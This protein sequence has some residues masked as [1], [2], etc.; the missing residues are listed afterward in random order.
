MYRCYLAAEEKEKA[1]YYKDLIL[2]QFP[3][4]EYARIITNPNYFKDAQRK[5][6]I[7]QVFYE[8]TYKAYVNG[9]Y[10]DVI[11]R[12]SA[13][14]SLFPPSNLTPKFNFTTGF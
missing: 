3:D 5:T 14:D 8:N 12:K 1:D 2:T 6:A 7:A 4:S 11:E 9:Q 10:L 13:A